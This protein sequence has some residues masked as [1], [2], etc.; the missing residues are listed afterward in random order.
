MKDLTVLVLL[1]CAVLLTG[2]NTMQGLGKDVSAL[3]NKIEKKAGEK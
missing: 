3:G 1:A 2:C